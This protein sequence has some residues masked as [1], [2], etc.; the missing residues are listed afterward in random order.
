MVD[1][2][3]RMKQN[4]KNRQKVMLFDHDKDPKEQRDVAPFRLEVVRE[5]SDHVAHYAERPV[6]FEQVPTVQLDAMRLGQLRALG[7]VDLD[8]PSKEDAL[9]EAREAAQRAVRNQ[10]AAAAETP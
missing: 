2:S 5:L 8:A 9:K 10:A 3:Y 4:L 1:G 7:Y 6:A